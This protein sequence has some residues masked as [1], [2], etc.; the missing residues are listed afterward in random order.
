VIASSG[1]GGPEHA[2]E[3]FTEAGADAAL[4]ASIFHFDEYS[5]REVKEY[6]DEHGVPVRL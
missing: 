1:C 5:I 2:R 3:V 6:L 4:A